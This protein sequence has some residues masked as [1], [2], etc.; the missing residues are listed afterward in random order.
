MNYITY[1]DWLVIVRSAMTFPPVSSLCAKFDVSSFS[2]IFGIC[3]IA[4]KEISIF[5]NIPK[6]LISCQINIWQ[7]DHLHCES[8]CSLGLS[9]IT[10]VFPH[11]CNSLADHAVEALSPSAHSALPFPLKEKML[12]NSLSSTFALLSCALK[13]PVPDV[14]LVMLNEEINM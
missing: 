12:H 5:L 1:R 7:S 11:C 9:A 6:T 2:F 4:K 13:I 10:N 3:L 8:G 14:H